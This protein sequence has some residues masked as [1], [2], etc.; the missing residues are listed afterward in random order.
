MHKSTKA[1]NISNS[2]INVIALGLDARGN[3]S[4]AVA[5]GY[6]TTV[7]ASG[8]AIGHDAYSSGYEGLG[9]QGNAQGSYAVS[10]GYSSVAYNSS[11][12]IGYNAAAWG[13][14]A[15]AIGANSRAKAYTQFSY[16]SSG[17]NNSNQNTIF[18]WGNS[19][20]SNSGISY[21][22]LGAGTTRSST[23]PQY[24]DNNSGLDLSALTNGY[25]RSM[26]FGT[27]TVM[28]KPTGDLNDDDVKVEEIKFVIT[29]TI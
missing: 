28:Y 22:G 1:N 3:S 13:D 9:I 20:F 17:Y 8:V 18:Q 21:I 14:F 23:Q 26:A 15:T 27:A 6:N 7:N 12:A 19:Q 5:I 2:N 4:Q 16:A 25:D 24:W 29:T 11:V 10:L